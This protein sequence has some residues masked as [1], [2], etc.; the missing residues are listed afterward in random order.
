[1]RLERCVLDKELKSVENVTTIWAICFAFALFAFIYDNGKSLIG[2]LFGY[3]KYAVV[4]L[5]T[6]ATFAL[7]CVAN[8]WLLTQFLANH[9]FAEVIQ[10]RLIFVI[11]RFS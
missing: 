6:Y 7:I 10:I 4:G 9:R 3:P 5:K 11:A 1:M 8:L 2:N